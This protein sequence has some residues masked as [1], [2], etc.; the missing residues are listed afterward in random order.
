M[1]VLQVT[2]TSD[3][4]M[5]LRILLSSLDSSRNWDARCY[6]RERLITFVNNRYPECLPQLRAEMSTRTLH[7]ATEQVPADVVRQPPV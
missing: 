3:K 6:V 1:V 5:Q 4:A 7:T 2:D